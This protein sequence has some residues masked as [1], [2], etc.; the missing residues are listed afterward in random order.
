MRKLYIIRS[1]LNDESIAM[2]ALCVDKIEE[3][4]FCAGKVTIDGLK[5]LSTAINN[6]SS[7]VS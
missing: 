1:Q 2:I 6:Q 4:K 7:P 3:L 5:I